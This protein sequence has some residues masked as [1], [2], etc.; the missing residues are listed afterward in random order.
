MRSKLKARNAASADAAGSVMPTCPVRS[1]A[2]STASTNVPDLLGPLAADDVAHLGGQVGG[3]EDVRAHRVLEVVAD[4]GD[5]VGPR[6]DLALGRGRGGAA[7]RVV[8]DAVE[9][10]AAEVERGERDVGAVDGV[11]V[12]ALREVGRERLLRRVAGG[13]VAAVVGRARWPPRAAG[14]GSAARAMPVATCADL[15]RVREPG[16]EMVVFGRD[17][18][19]ALAGEPPPR[20]R[21]LHPVEV[22]LEAQAVRVG[23]LGPARGPRR[24][25]GRARPAPTARRAPPPAPRGDAT[26]PTDERVRRPRAR[27][28]PHG[29]GR[30]SAQDDHRGVIDAMR[31]PG[32]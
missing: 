15:D 14:T 24:R 30:F 16:A 2:S 23:V 6:H 8:A 12:A 31:V 27:A 4:V 7:P 22:A 21:V 28:E 1:M 25:P 17:E 20:P 26:P 10:L 19:L 32:R 18:H 13:A 3:L 9:G 29:S 5:P 11:V